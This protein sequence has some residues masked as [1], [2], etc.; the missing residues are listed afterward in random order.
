MKYW[1]VAYSLENQANN[2]LQRS[3]SGKVVAIAYWVFYLMLIPNI[4]FPIYLTVEYIISNY[5]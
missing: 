5:T 4:G 3:D 2:N 1:I